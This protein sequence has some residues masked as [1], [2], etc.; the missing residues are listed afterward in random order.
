MNPSIVTHDNNRYTLFM[1]CHI[2]IRVS[3]FR[4]NMLFKVYDKMLSRFTYK[5]P[6]FIN[7]SSSQEGTSIFD[8]LRLNA[9]TKS[10]AILK[11]VC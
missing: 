2:Y 9:Q 1:H 11:I 6:C 3:I 8:V 7:L 10:F 4:P 5:N